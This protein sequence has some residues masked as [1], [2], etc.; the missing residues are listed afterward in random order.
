MNFS[1]VNIK[2]IFFM[3]MGLNMNY[4]GKIKKNNEL[5]IYTME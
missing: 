3:K 1:N 5:N 2:I 4:Y